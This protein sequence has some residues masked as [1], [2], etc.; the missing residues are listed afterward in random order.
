M[1]QKVFLLKMNK[2]TL[3][4]LK[5]ILEE[6]FGYKPNKVDLQKLAVGLVGYFDLLIKI[7]N[8]SKVPKSSP[9]PY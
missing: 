6:E 3:N 1:V 2:K 5:I 7:S 9:K 8:R 4:E